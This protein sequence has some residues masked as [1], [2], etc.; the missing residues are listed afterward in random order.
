MATKKT[1]PSTPA[2]RAA[3][4]EVKLYDV[5]SSLDH[6]GNRYEDGDQ[7]ELNDAHAAPL[8]QLGVVTLVKT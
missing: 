8:L 6:D 3:A 5:H 7:V 1:A 4:A 2:T